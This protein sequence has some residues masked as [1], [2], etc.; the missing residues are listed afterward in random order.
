[1]GNLKPTSS[2]SFKVTPD[3]QN[4]TAEWLED[5]SMR[6]VMSIDMNQHTSEALLCCVFACEGRMLVVGSKDRKLRVYDVSTGNLVHTLSG[7]QA[8]VCS[9]CNHGSLVSSGGDHG[10]SSLITWDVNFWTT[11]SKVQLHSASVTCI[12][13]LKDGTH[14]A[15]ASYDR[16][17]SI[18]NHKRGVGILSVSSSRTGIGCMVMSSDKE[19]LITASLDNSI[20]IW[21]LSR[22][23][24][25]DSFR[26]PQYQTLSTKKLS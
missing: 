17:I 3:Q 1:M 24:N 8:N 23:V 26:V 5:V 15:T 12:V 11:R 19:R 14:L 10:C 4:I 6:E 2:Q 21:H 20:S 22:N 7:H 13:D 9:L 18:F 16:K 25:L